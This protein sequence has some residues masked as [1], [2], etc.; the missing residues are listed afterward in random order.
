MLLLARRGLVAHRS[1]TFST[2]ARRLL[3]S[4]SGPTTLDTPFISDTIPLAEGRLGTVVELLAQPGQSVD[5]NEV[6]AVVETDKVSLDVKASRP[7]V[8]A[9]V[10]VDL[11]DE[12]NEKQPLYELQ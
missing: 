4:A 5:E 12:V 7:G 10:L 3:C 1:S 11:G 8:I 6:I 2:Q 9:A